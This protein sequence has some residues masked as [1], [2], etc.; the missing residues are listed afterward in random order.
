M[1]RRESVLKDTEMEEV[2]NDQIIVKDYAN[3]SPKETDFGK[4]T[5]RIALK[6]PHGSNG[7]LVKNLYLSCDPYMGTR[8]NNKKIYPP[9]FT[10]GEVY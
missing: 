7:V 5:G 9:P 1:Y 10:L 3:G 6:L 4:K 2:K 8:F